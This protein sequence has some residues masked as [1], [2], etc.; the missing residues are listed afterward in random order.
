VGNCWKAPIPLR[1]AILPIG[2]RHIYSVLSSVLL[3]IL[4]S[5]TDQLTE[6][7]FTWS[8]SSHEQTILAW[9]T[10]YGY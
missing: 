7:L 4:N 10:K 1:V 5:D 9:S 6:Q 8:T 2:S 3:A